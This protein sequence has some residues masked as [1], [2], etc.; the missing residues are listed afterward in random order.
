V[1]GFGLVDDP[2]NRDREFEFGIRQE[3]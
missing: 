2:D 3:F 1:P